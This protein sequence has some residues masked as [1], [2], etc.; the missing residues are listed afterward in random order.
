MNPLTKS[1]IKVK[2]TEPPYFEHIAVGIITIGVVLLGAIATA[3]YL[4][5][6]WPG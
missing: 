5:I 3:I 2:L 1:L 4:W 6:K